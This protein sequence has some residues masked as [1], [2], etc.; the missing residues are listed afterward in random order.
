MKKLLL[1]I[2]ALLFSTIINAQERI[3]I[4]DICYYDKNMN[5]ICT[6]EQDAVIRNLQKKGFKII[7][8]EYEDGEGAGG[9]TMTFKYVTM[10]QAK[11]ATKSTIGP[12]GTYSIEFK[13]N[14]EARE[15]AAN[16][17]RTGFFTKEEDNWYK[18][19]REPI[20]GISDFKIKYNVIEFILSVP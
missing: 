20:F 7:K 10:Q 4:L 16:A 1:I 5:E 2:T 8:T 3:S 17:V 18:T 12:E 6:H 19:T 15:F 11:F 14:S 13:T 9:Y